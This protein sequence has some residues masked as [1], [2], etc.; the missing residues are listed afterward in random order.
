MGD[1]QRGRRRQR[2]LEAD[3]PSPDILTYE[4]DDEV[5]AFRRRADERLV[6]EGVVLQGGAAAVGADPDLD[7][8]QDIPAVRPDEQDDS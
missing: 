6:A 8:G 7:A 2:P 3:K 5:D 1:G 4:D